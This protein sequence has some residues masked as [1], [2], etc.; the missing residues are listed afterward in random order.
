MVLVWPTPLLN[1]Q[2][3]YK[4][5]GMLAYSAGSMTETM[6]SLGLGC[7]V[8]THDMES[9]GHGK[10]AASLQDAGWRLGLG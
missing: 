4:T 5:D 10:G 2:S 3:L 7:V 9:S 8:L 6:H 1:G